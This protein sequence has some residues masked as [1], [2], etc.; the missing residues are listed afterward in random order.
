MEDNGFGFGNVLPFLRIG[1]AGTMK[2]PGVFEMMEL[3]GA[4]ESAKRLRKAFDIFDS[5]KEA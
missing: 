4:E 2:G 5:I 1:L 3:L